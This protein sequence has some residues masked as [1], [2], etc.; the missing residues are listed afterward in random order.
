[1][2][3]FLRFFWI[4]NNVSLFQKIPK[5]PTPGIQLNVQ[6][7]R[8][9][10]NWKKAIQRIQ[11]V[12]LHMTKVFHGI[13]IQQSKG[14]ATKQF[15]KG[16]P[17]Q[18]KSHGSPHGQAQQKRFKGK[19]VKIPSTFGVT[20]FLKTGWHFETRLYNLALSCPSFWPN[21]E[22]ADNIWSKFLKSSLRKQAFAPHDPLLRSSPYSSRSPKSMPSLAAC[23]TKV[24]TSN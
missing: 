14:N 6:P 19:T 3:N 15:T 5:P 16:S 7:K 18:S 20:W 2:F 24:S 1:M 11:I 22:L 8:E 12:K 23:S 17:Q 13:V 4:K 10:I 21:L 9:R